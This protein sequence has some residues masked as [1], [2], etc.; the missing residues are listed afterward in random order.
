ME[1]QYQILIVLESVLGLKNLGGPWAIYLIKSKSYLDLYRLTRLSV[2]YLKKIPLQPS[3]LLVTSDNSMQK[4]CE[5]LS[6]PFYDPE[7]E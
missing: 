7:T 6:I 4:V 2:F 1:R 5:Q 3:P